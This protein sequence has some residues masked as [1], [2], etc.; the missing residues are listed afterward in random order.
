MEPGQGGGD[1]KSRSGAVFNDGM[2]LQI[3]RF[4]WCVVRLTGP[5]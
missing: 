3:K 2:L 4:V 5:A 1:V